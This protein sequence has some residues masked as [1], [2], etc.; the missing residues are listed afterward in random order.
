MFRIVTLPCRA[1]LFDLDG[2]LADSTA[3]VLH[4]WR[5]WFERHGLDAEALMPRVHGRRAIDTIRDIAP[6]LDAQAELAALVAAEAGDTA[7][8]TPIP[9]AAALL[10]SLPAD[11]WA[12]VTSGVR[13]VAL[14]RLRACGLPEPVHLVP[15]D[16]ITR[17]KPDPEGYLRG[18]AHLGVAPAD[19]IV[20]EDAPAGI[21]AARNAGMR[22]VAL[23]TTHAAHELSA[24]DVI[25]RDLRDVRVATDAVPGA[26][27]V[28]C[29]PSHSA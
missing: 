7:G 27:T 8:V 21:G 4:H 23:A 1:L 29:A 14:A 10:A 16:E 12:V 9:G 22:V 13:Q 20:L 15:A 2:V 5:V 11:R 18:A 24:A 19:C 6:A 17:G 28:S 25:V 3:S 26:L